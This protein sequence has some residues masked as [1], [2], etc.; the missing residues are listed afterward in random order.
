MSST[1]LAYDHARL[2]LNTGDYT[3]N[4]DT[5]LCLSTPTTTRLRVHKLW[6]LSAYDYPRL[7]LYTPLALHAYS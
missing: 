4:D 6:P 5:R 7:R 3:H 1:S 2:C